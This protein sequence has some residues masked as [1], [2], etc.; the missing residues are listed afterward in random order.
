MMNK[1]RGMTT[2]KAKMRE[3]RYTSMEDVLRAGKYKGRT[4]KEMLVEGNYINDAYKR[5]SIVMTRALWLQCLDYKAKHKMSEMEKKP[6]TT[7]VKINS[8]KQYQERAG[9]KARRK[10]RE[11]G[12][13]CIHDSCWC[14]HHGCNHRARTTCDQEIQHADGSACCDM[15]HWTDASN[16]KVD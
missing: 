14:A 16:F 10:L 13:P 5:G 11:T 8:Y 4:I 15:T 6:Y 2:R 12:E 9:K 3:E 1:K 7:P